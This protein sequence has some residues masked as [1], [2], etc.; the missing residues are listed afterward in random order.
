MHLKHDGP[1]GERVVIVGTGETGAIAYEYFTSGSRHEVVAFSAESPFITDDVHC[2]L[3]VVPFEDLA[4]RYPPDEYRAFIAVSD[5]QLNRVRRRLYQAVK[6]AGYGCVSC[7]SDRAFRLPSAQFGENLF[8]QEFTSLQH[9]VSIGDNVFLSSGTCVGHSSTV[10]D[11]CYTGPHAVICGGVTIRRG[12]FLGANCCVAETVTIGE[13]CIIGAG[14]L[15][16]KDTKP[17]Q[18]Y[19]GVPARPTGRDSFATVGVTA[20]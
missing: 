3:P 9:G 1:A 19:I 20:G 10:G 11:D 2:G 7:L 6:E 13:D 15:V 18:V 17:G 16:L 5:I 4:R 8:A 14:A 12:A